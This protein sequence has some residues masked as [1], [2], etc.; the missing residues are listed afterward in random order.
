MGVDITLERAR[1]IAR[2]L[3]AAPKRSLV[4][5]KVNGQRFTL[6]RGARST[7][8]S[9]FLRTIRFFSSQKT[10]VCA[11]CG[12]QATHAQLE[13]NPQWPRYYLMRW[14]A[15]DE[16]LTIDHKIPISKGGPKNKFQNMQV[17]C[18]RC[19]NK[20]GNDPLPEEAE[21]D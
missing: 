21:E 5:A 17:A 1:K 19:N 12:K 15:G 6:R 2:K 11:L 4:H 18:L 14:Y 9:G 16:P 13:V 8:R 3:L 10:K 20:R 7:N